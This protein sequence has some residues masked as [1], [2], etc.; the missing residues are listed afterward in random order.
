MK[1]AL[2]KNPIPTERIFFRSGGD[3]VPILTKNSS[4]SVMGVQS[5]GLPSGNSVGGSANKTFLGSI[6][7]GDDDGNGPASAIV[8]GPGDIFFP[9]RAPERKYPSVSFETVG[10]N[11]FQPDSVQTAAATAALLQSI[12]D[13]RFKATEA[14]P[15]EDYFATQKLAKAVDD[16]SRNAG[17]EDLG[18]S[19]EIMRNLVATRRKASEDDFMRR[20]LD[21][22]MSAADAQT[23]VDNVRRANALAETKKV[24]DREYQSKLLIQRIAKSRGIMSSVNEPLTSSGAIENP[25]LNQRMADASGQPENAFGSSPLDRDRIFMTPDFYKRM[26]RKTALTQEAGDTMAALANATA[27]ATG[28]VPTPSMLAGLER[29]AAI[30]RARDAVASRLESA[31][32]RK[33]T[34]PLAVILPPFETV[35]ENAYGSKKAGSQSTFQLKSI[36]EL[37][38]FECFLA[39]NQVCNLDPNK[40]P[41]LRRILGPEQ[42]RG[43]GDE[44]ASNILMILKSVTSKLIGN[45]DISIPKLTSRSVQPKN[46]VQALESVKGMDKTQLREIQSYVSSSGYDAQFDMAFDGAPAG[47]PL[48]PPIDTRSREKQIEDLSSELQRR[49][50]RDAV[51]E[52]GEERR[53][54]V[55]A[56]GVRVGEAGR[57][58]P[59]LAGAGGGG[60]GAARA[61]VRPGDGVVIGGVRYTKTSVDRMNREEL[62]ALAGTIGIDTTGMGVP[63]LKGAIKA[64]LNML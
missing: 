27:Q 10:F 14:A 58:A 46:I 43:R 61:V 40:L 15:F 49:T 34:G 9:Y 31:T 42:L 55:G 19:R 21:A 64:G 1:S 39:L 7:M 11:V 2:L 29:E 32:Q 4:Q 47:T 26:L 20:A 50:I 13:S 54:V 24:D 41:E 51:R 35:L 28:I 56:P 18:Y 38:S 8:G 5:F 30:T 36:D 60:G 45:S 63:Q 12:G 44:P 53:A 22:G 3:G 57:A 62:R 37:N 25:Q 48:P 33:I 16:A 6:R 52:L 17:L 23:E 59:A